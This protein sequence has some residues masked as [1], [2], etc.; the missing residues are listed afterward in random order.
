MVAVNVPVP[1]VAVMLIVSKLPRCELNPVPVSSARHASP[2][3]N[4][5]LAIRTAM[6]SV[7]GI[8]APLGTVTAAVSDPHADD[9]ATDVLAVTCVK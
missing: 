2:V 6:V 7:P 5:P 3:V 9:G 4:A 8:T 1:L